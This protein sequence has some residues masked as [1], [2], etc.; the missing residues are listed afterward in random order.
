[1]SMLNTG[2]VMKRAWLKMLQFTLKGLTLCHFMKI[3]NFLLSKKVK[4]LK[5]YYIFVFCTVK[6]LPSNS[7]NIPNKE[8]KLN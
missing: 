2:K 5:R 3:Y 8:P 6:Y 7:K 1:M 4:I